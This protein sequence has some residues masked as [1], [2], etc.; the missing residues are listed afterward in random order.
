MTAAVYTAIGIL[1]IVAL[2]RRPQALVLVLAISFGLSVGAAKIAHGDHI[3]PVLMALDALTVIAAWYLW[4]KHQSTRASLIAWLGLCKILLGVSAGFSPLYLTWAAANNAL[5]VV[6]IL[7]AGGFTDGITAWLG[8][9][10]S[11]PG[12]GG[13]GLLR[14]LERDQ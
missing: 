12:A 14:H 9:S 7:V 13:T 3:R 4:G 5:F 10:A 1:L 6:M 8:R 2:I 11:R